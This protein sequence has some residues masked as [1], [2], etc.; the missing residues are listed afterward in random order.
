M[1]FHGETQEVKNATFITESTV[2][3]SHCPLSGL[4]RGTFVIKYALSLIALNPT[5]PFNTRLKNSY[6]SN[7]TRGILNACSFKCLNQCEGNFSR[8]NAVGRGITHAN[9]ICF[10]MNTM[11]MLY[12][13]SY[14]NVGL[15][16]CENFN[17]FGVLIA[18]E[19]Y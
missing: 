8:L 16:P 10:N 2:L 14:L 11:L 1:P 3:I 4:A 9:D 7:W 19:S 15:R 13:L 18:F 6:L 5:N 12:K 17:C